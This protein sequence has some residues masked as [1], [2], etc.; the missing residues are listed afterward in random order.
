MEKIW[1]YIDSTDGLIRR[2]GQ[3]FTVDVPSLG[4]VEYSVVLNPNIKKY[5]AVELSSGMG[6]G[7]HWNTKTQ[8]IENAE[9]ALLNASIE[10]LRSKIRLGKRYN[11]N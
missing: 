7:E 3:L 5:V 1:F 2:Q 8:A 6:F 4:M 10:I 9:R 11:V